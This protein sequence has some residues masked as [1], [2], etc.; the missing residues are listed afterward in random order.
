MTTGYYPD[1]KVGVW[2]DAETAYGTGAGSADELGKVTNVNPTRT[3]NIQRFV[4][5]GEG[6][7]E[8]THLYGPVDIPITL[9]WQMLSFASSPARSVSTDLLKYIIGG[10]SGSGTT[11]APYKITES[12][13]YGYTAASDVLTFQLIVA[14]EGVGSATPVDSTDTYKGCIMTNCR[15]NSTQGSVLTASAD[16]VA[17]SVTSDATD[18]DSFTSDVNVPWVFQQGAFKWGATP[19]AVSKIRSFS[20]SIAANPFIYRALGSRFIQEPITGKRTYD[21]TASVIMSSDLATSMRD[22]HYGQ[23]NSFIAG[24]DPATITADD[25]IELNFAQ[26]AVSGDKTMSFYLDQC[27]IITMSEPVSLGAGLVESQFTGCAQT[28]KTDFCK[29]WVIT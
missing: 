28:G 11:A 1:F 19:T 3:D 26:G 20:L 15:L 29:Y 6:R 27:S 18:V 5:I 4:G 17:Q 10:I 14:K 2:I 8:N 23:A 21:W 25:E 9:D 7:N 12:N 22:D 16:I 24:I 13:S